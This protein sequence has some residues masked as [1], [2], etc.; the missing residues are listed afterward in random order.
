[1]DFS[2]TQYTFG[3]LYSLSVFLMMSFILSWGVEYGVF[4]LL[5]GSLE[6]FTS[7][8]TYMKL[9]QLLFLPSP[10]SA[11]HSRPALL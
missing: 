8:Y 2:S 3:W 4:C 10:T 11:C 5:V 9:F 1:M 7:L 6:S